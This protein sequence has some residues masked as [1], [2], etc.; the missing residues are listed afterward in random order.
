MKDGKAGD[1][2]TPHRLP[3]GVNSNQ[4]VVCGLEFSTLVLT[5]SARSAIMRLTAK[6]EVDAGQRLV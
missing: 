2:D 5:A 1:G 3:T 4:S 6:P